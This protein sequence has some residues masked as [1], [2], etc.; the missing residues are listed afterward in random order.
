MHAQTSTDVMLLLS[1]KLEDSFFFI[2]S[3]CLNKFVIHKVSISF[4]FFFLAIFQIR[5]SG[6]VLFIVFVDLDLNAVR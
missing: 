4:S 5:A 3:V 2:L 1:T 6:Q